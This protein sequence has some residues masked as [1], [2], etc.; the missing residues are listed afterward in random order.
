MAMPF[1]GSRPHHQIAARIGAMGLLAADLGARDRAQM[2]LVRAIDEL[3]RTAPAPQES[4]WR[5]RRQAH[6]AVDLHRP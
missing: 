5:I 2:D 4:Q 6:R 1:G 3:Q